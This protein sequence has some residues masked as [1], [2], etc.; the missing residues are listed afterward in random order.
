VLAGVELSLRNVVEDA[1]HALVA[2]IKATAAQGFKQCEDT[3]AI[4]EGIDK[5]R[6][7]QCAEI[8]LE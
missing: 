3:F 5:G 6:D 2:D 4:A 7:S 1:A 8:R